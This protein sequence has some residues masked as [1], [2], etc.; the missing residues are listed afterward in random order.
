MES[1]ISRKLLR[2]HFIKGALSVFFLRIFQ[3][4]RA[5]RENMEMV[6]WIGKCSLLLKRLKDSWMDVLPTNNVSETR[7]QNQYHAD[8]ARENEER[9]SRSQELL[10]PDLPETREDRWQPTKDC[11]HSV[12]T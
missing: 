3:F 12:I 7:R 2:H 10:N 5:K 11:F 4:I 9:R 8:V 6:K 1:S